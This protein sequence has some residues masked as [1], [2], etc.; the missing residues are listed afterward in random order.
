MH[1]AVLNAVCVAILLYSVSYGQ[2]ASAQRDVFNRYCTSCH[3]D[4][5][6]T[7]GLLLDKM[8]PVRV[9]DDAEQWEK[10]VRKLR[11]N[12]MPPAGVARPDPATYDFVASY[13]EKELD[14]SAAKNPNVGKL[15]LLHRLTRT[16]Y[17]N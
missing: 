12:A 13:L 11:T 6:K 3:N 1:R 2:T 15:P 16:E 8:D 10:V 17:Q 14:L 9:A 5:L 7:A 4:K